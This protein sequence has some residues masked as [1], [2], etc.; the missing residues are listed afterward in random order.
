MTGRVNDHG[1]QLTL[2]QQRMERVG[3]L[4]TSASTIV[5]RHEAVLSRFEDMERDRAAK[6]RE[7]ER[8]KAVRKEVLGA[9]QWMGAVLLFAA[10]ALNL[11]EADKAK[12]LLGLLK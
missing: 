3:G 11:I 1:Q 6:K 12:G 5:S 2:I 8:R 4:V 10:A 9:A 7:S